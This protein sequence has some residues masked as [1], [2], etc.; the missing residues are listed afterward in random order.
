MSVWVYRVTIAVPEAEVGDANA[1]ALVIGT[2]ERDVNVFGELWAE[3]G[4]GERYAIACTH[5]R[6]DF[7]SRATD[8][9]S[10]PPHAPWADIAAAT[11][12]QGMLVIGSPETP[13]APA[14]DRI[15]VVLGPND[16]PDPLPSHLSEMGLVMQTAENQ[17][18]L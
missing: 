14:P 3:D 18:E 16:D 4:A 6:A 12:A 15:A 8:T 13:P 9:L 1:L 17:Q 11:R 7:P 10:A 2:H 5:A